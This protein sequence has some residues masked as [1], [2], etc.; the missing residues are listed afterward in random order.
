MSRGL[1]GA[2]S[3]RPSELRPVLAADSNREP[4]DA[5]DVP[6]ESVELFLA[7]VGRFR[8]PEQPRGR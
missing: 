8:R 4:E 1:R 3:D 7:L 2:L 5:P 6:R